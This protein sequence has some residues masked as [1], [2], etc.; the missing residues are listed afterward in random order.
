[1]LKI[2]TIGPEANGAVVQ[3][4]GQIIGPWVDELERTCDRLLT[5]SP[6]TLDLSGVSF[7]ERRGVQLLRSLGTRGVPLLHCSPFVAEQLKVQA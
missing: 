6:I 3:L 1:V 5:L 2:V 4:E 7:I